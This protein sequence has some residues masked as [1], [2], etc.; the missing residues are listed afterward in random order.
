M[1]ENELIVQDQIAKSIYLVRG[2]KAMMD[3]KLAELYGVQTRV[4]N[5]AV[6]RNLERFPD[7]FMFQLT[8]DEWENLKSQD[9]TSS[10]GGRR[11]LPYMFTEQ[12]IAMLSS[13]L[14]SPIAIQVNIS[15][16]RVFVKMRQWAVSY[17]DLLHKIEE[18]N[19]NQTEHSQHI[20]NIYK[21]M[22]ELVRPAITERKPI[23]FK[24]N[25]SE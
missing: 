25:E 23:G 19:Q 2:Y 4:L 11:T 6:K 14:N 22:E 8:A 13:V 20:Q 7:D 5:Q 10:W 3:S 24:R 18:L 1:K 17:K 16:M 9:V 21:I 12:G 15:I